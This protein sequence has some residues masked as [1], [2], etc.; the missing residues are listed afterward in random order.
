MSKSSNLSA[1]RIA[2]VWYSNPLWFFNKLPWSWNCENI[3]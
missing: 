2:I 3:K 1:I